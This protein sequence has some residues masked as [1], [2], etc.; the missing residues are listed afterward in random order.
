MMTSSTVQDYWRAVKRIMDILAGATTTWKGKRYNIQTDGYAKTAH[1]RILT[2]EK[3][4]EDGSVLDK[5]ITLYYLRHTYCTDLQKAG[6]PINIARYLMGH[7]DISTTT[8]IY[9]HSGEDDATKAKE[10]I[11]QYNSQNKQK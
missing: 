7:S 4:G 6:V 2:E 11:D 1:G 10:N 5:D 3:D 9:T 8:K